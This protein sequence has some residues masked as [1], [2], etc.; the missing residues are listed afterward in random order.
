MLS[1]RSLLLTAALIPLA[2]AGPKKPPRKPDIQFLK[3]STS[4][5]EGAI[6]YEG[7]LRVTGEKPV[8]GLILHIEFLDTEGILLTQQKIETT[9][10]TLAPGVEKHFAV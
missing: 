10:D 3:V 1:R 8:A 6:T 9:E 2:F 4:R 7:D 5:Q